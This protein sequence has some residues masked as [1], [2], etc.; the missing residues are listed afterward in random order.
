MN[1]IQKHIE[2]LK[3]NPE[4]YWFKRKLYGWGCTPARM[5]GWFVF[6]AYIVAVLFFAVR[7]EELM[8]L[9]DAIR[10]VIAPI[11]VLTILLMF[12]CYMTGEKP[13]WQWGTRVD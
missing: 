9:A 12:V 6:V 1:I 11:V 5:Q 13:K 8:P 7:A 3:D 2:Y 4:G 10:E